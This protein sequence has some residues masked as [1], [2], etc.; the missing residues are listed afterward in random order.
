MSII[1]PHD[2]LK[3]REHLVPHDLKTMYD[4]LNSRRFGVKGKF[5]F[6]VYGENNELYVYDW[7][8]TVK[9]THG[10]LMRSIESYGYD[11]SANFY[12][13]VL[14]LAGYKPQWIKLVFLHKAAKKVVEVKVSTLPSWLQK[15]F[16]SQESIDR[17]DDHLSMMS[18]DVVVVDIE[19]E[20]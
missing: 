6:I 5:D 12:R 19:V 2:V 10:E 8:T 14:Y 4:Y 15:T 9:K 18:N 17:L 20:K 3:A 16:R 11:F 1:I 13:L 7:K